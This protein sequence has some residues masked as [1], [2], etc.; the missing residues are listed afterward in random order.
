VKSLVLE[1]VRGTRAAEA[2]QIGLTDLSLRIPMDALLSKNPD[3]RAWSETP[4][5]ADLCAVPHYK[6]PIAEW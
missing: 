2:L 6:Q 4:N 5:W 1:Y 3:H